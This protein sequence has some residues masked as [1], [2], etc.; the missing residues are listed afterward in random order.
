[1]LESGRRLGNYEIVETLGVGG[2]GEVYRVTD[3]KLKREEAIKV[4]PE[5]F[6]QDA[7]RMKRFEREAQFLASLNHPNI[8]TL[9]GLEEH[10]GIPSSSWRLSKA[11][12]LPN[13]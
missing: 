7:E 4:L 2:M 10:D 9:H 11:R 5:A 3:R 1:M 12:R 13:V 6:A 8:A